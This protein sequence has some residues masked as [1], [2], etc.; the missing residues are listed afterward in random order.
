MNR[1]SGQD[2]AFRVRPIV[3]V[4]TLA[5][6]LGAMAVGEA[7]AGAGFTEQVSVDSAG[8]RVTGDS[9]NASISADGR[10]VAFHSSSSDLVAGDNNAVFD[11]FVHD[12][13]TGQTTRVSVDDAGNQG[14]NNSRNPSI[15]ADGRYV[16]FHSSSADLVAGDTNGFE[17]IFVHDRQTGQTTRVSV[18]NTGIPGNDN[19]TMPSISA[20]GR[21]VA[22]A[23]YA[24]NLVAGDNNGFADIFVHDRQTG[25]TTRV[26]VDSAGNQ[27]EKD[28]LSPSISADGRYV[29]F[30]T[31]S[32]LVAGDTNGTSDVFVRDR[33]TGVTTRVS[34]D[35]AGNEG[36]PDSLDPSISADGRYV[37]FASDATTLVAGDNNGFGDIFVHDRQTGQTTRVS[38]DSAGNQANGFSYQC[39]ISANGQRVAFA[40]YA[41]N[42]V[43][44]DNNTVADVF[45][46]DRETGQTTRVSLGSA[47]NQGDGDSF[48]T[49]I[50][51][52]GRYV[53]FTTEATNLVAG[54]TNGEDDILVRRFH[55]APYDLDN[56]G[57]TDVAVWRQDSGIWYILRSLDGTMVSQQWGLG[58]LGDIPVSGDY[59]GDRKTD[60]AV[61]R[62]DSGYWYILRSLDRTM[63]SQQWGLGSLNDVPVP[64]DYDGDGKT[65]VAVWR[66]DSGIWYILRSS[67]GTMATQQWGLG[68]LNDIPVPGDYDG[69][70]KTDVAVWRPSSGIWYILR[71][72]DGTMVSR[73]W[74]L[75]SLG[76]IPVPGD[77][78]VDGKADVAVWRPDSGYWFILRSLD[79]AMVSQQWGLGSLNDV[80][81][82]GDYD[83]DGKT[84]VAVW[85]QDSGIWYILRSSDVTMVSQQWGLGSLGDVPIN[86]E[87]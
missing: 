19:S 34:V 56:D 64:G 49:S 86:G 36:D 21:Y 53:A 16:A 46:H 11:V 85:R 74:G 65:D 23:S 8:N 7:R 81:V 72:S 29:A 57:K 22:F 38:V 27:G 87:Q 79:G 17:D 14:D 52:D 2:T 58:S 20:D 68:S 84:D 37:A 47:G 70:G 12:R 44:G 33:Q 32:T 66:Q 80:P 78:D 59:D 76:D 4:A 63:V 42:L 5:F 10:Y 50:S 13:R 62:P 30:E 1:K 39:T 75:G 31:I 45:L 40:S 83:G 69:D 61:W 77:Y 55:T 71:S 25:Q 3:Y 43:A 60:V 15:S 51:A 24:T 28:C 67:D 54:D 26:S 9:R 18:D 82:P 6:L 73:Q 41:S 48:Y 35:S